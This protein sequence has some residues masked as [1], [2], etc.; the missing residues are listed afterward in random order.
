M[1]LREFVDMTDEERWVQV[2]SARSNQSSA[3]GVISPDILDFLVILLD[4]LKLDKQA[5]A[6]AYM[7]YMAGETMDVAE[8]VQEAKGE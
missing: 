1:T 4:E 8:K 2:M 5:L 3:G 6:N 7:R